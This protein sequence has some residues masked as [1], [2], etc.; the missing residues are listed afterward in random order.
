MSKNVLITGGAGFVG[1][2]L[3]NELI[4]HGYKVHLFDALLPQVHGARNE[5]PAYLDP[6][7]E[8]IHGNICDPGAVRRACRNMDIV[9]HLAARVGVGQSMYEVSRYTETNNGGTAVLMEELIQRPVGCLVVAS[10]MSI[11][12]EGLYRRRNGETVSGQTRSLAQLQAGQWDL[13]DEAG[14]PLQPIPT[15]ED[16]RPELASVYALSK[17]DQERMCMI[18]GN[19]YQIPTVALRF[20]NIYGSL[21]ALSNPYTGVLAIFASRLLN[22]TPPLIY[23]D[24]YQRR[25]FVHVHDIARACRLAAETPEAAHQVFNI[26]SGQ[27]FTIREL[28]ARLS[29]VLNKEELVPEITGKYRVGDIRHCFADISRAQQVLGYRPT[30]TLAEGL[31]ELTSWLKEQKAV[32]PVADAE[33]ELVSR[34][35]IV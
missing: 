1:A 21:Q 14:E 26:G 24:G 18:I 28:A 12:G 4:E 25:D 33:A 17:Y 15:T 11:Y 23:E 32:D 31:R 27:V 29:T 13:M 2:H 35:L 30:V 7:I 5:W 8:L 22:N 16:K 10:S 20:F 6:S 9:Y 34:G 19:A 3:A